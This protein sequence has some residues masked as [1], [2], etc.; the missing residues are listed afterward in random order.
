[1]KI[2]EWFESIMIH[3][4]ARRILYFEYAM[5][6]TRNCS[7]KKWKLRA[8]FKVRSWGSDETRTPE[9]RIILPDS[10]LLQLKCESL[11]EQSKPK[12][13]AV[14]QEQQNQHDLQNDQ[15]D[16][17]NSNHVKQELQDVEEEKHDVSAVPVPRPD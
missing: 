9:P 11:Q 8:E 12:K 14:T 17:D 5:Y 1:M 2:D 15:P 3:E 16:D 6:F 4:K 10:Q 7:V 13:Q